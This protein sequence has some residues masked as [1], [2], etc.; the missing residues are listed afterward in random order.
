LYSWVCGL[1]TPAQ[2][3]EF[4]G[5]TVVPSEPPAD[6]MALSRKFSVDVN[7]RFVMSRGDA[8]E[9][10][11][12]SETTHYLD[13]KTVE[14][15]LY[16]HG[17]VPPSPST[18]AR[19]PR[20]SLVPASKTDVFQHPMGALDKRRLMKFIQV[21]LCHWYCVGLRAGCVSTHVFHPQ[22]AMDRHVES[23]SSVG[24]IETLNE[25]TL[26]QGRSLTRCVDAVSPM[27]G[28]ISLSCTRFADLRIRQRPPHLTWTRLKGNRFGSFWN[29]AT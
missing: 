16:L 17:P 8:V 15:L 26:G 13:F 5:S 18:F 22:F 7:P 11:V 3:A 4:S 10:L 9:L 6:L 20:M 25:V 21:W 2:Y 14:A 24:G 29:R 1:T 28:P 23:D 19:D 27:L 12:R